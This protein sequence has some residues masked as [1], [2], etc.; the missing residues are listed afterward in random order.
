MDKQTIYPRPTKI[1][2]TCKKVFEKPLNFGKSHW[3]KRKFC[4]RKC[5][6]NY[7]VGK[8]NEL[9]PGWKGENVLVYS[10]HKWLYKN[11]GKANKCENI[12]CE[13]KS[14]WFEWAKKTECEYE[15]KRENFMMLCRKCHRKYDMTPEKREK[16]I[17]NLHWYKK[18]GELK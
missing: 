1:C 18:G 10:K 5:E 2:K 8:K 3:E 4:N 12:K 6:A 7:R 15:K 14:E 16:A 17:M 9:A 13:G 11:Y